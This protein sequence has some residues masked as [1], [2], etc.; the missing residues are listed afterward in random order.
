[1]NLEIRPVKSNNYPLSAIL[2]KGN[3]ALYWLSEIERM[4]LSLENITVYPIPNNLPN[5]IWGCLVE[6]TSTKIELVSH[7]PHLLCQSVHQLLFIPENSDVYPSIDADELKSVLNSVKHI[8]HTDFGLYR[9]DSAID[10]TEIL[11]LYEPIY[12]D[13]IQ[14]EPSAFIPMNIHSVR[15]ESLNP[16]SELDNL[17]KNVVPKTEKIE[18][19]PLNIIESIKRFALKSLFTSTKDENENWKI[20]KKKSYSFLEKIGSLFSNSK[21]ESVTEKLEKDLED[22]EKRNSSEMEKL[23]NMLKTNPDLALKYSIPI[24]NF[25]TNRGD[26]HGSFRMSK[27]WSNFDLFSGLSSSGGGFTIHDNSMFELQIQYNKMAEDYIKAENYE[28]AAFIYMKLLKNYYSAATTLEKG[29]LYSSAATIYLKYLQ[30]K[31]KAAQCYEEVRMTNEAIALYKE[32]NQYEKIGDLL[33]EMNSTSEAKKYYELV[34]DDLVEKNKNVSASLIL[35]NKMNETARAQDIL[36]KGWK[37][38]KDAYNC[39]NLYF[40][41]IKKHDEKILAIEN[42]FQNG[43]NTENKSTFVKILKTEFKK[44][45]APPKMKDMAYQL[46]SEI[47][48][49]DQE[50][51]SYLSQFNSDDIISRDIWRYKSI[52][53]K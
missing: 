22:L 20:E 34:V 23:I 53:N 21:V 37:E 2:I 19:K 4:N 31:L 10:W 52:K 13:I 16:E 39:L 9:L 27:L 36:I 29:K 7:H 43:L 18:D 12:Y 28:K 5:T 33:S 44:N 14:P 1:M 42:I 8:Y 46:I 6:M 41:N 50:I 51:L 48:S 3:D 25:G 49:Y 45:T 17:I 38:N 32:L 15:V 40:N 47:A 30:N 35:Q 24:D 11:T 26:N